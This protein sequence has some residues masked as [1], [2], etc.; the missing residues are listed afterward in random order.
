MK[1]MLKVFLLIFCMLIPLQA[2]FGFEFKGFGD[3]VFKGQTTETKTTM[4]GITITDKSFKDNF[5]LGNFTIYATEQLTDNLDALIEIVY[6]PAMTGMEMPMFM[7]ARGEIGY[8][9]GDWLNLRAGKFH[10]PL[11]YYSNVIRHVSYFD[12]AIHRPEILRFEM[13][14]GFLSLHQIG[15]LARGT[16]KISPGS[17]D[18]TAMISNGQKMEISEMSMDVMLMTMGELKP[19]ETTDD[20]KNKQITL[21]LTF[22]PAFLDGLG[23][24]ISGYETELHG[25]D[26]S[27]STQPEVLDT[28]QLVTE[29]HLYYNVLP[30]DI[31]SE[32]Y[33]INN[34]DKEAKKD[35]SNSAYF[36]QVAYEFNE[37]IRPYIRY[38][39]LSIKEQ[40]PYFGALRK[41]NKNIILGG[42]RY[43]LTPFS[44]IKIELKRAKT[45]G[46][47]T[48]TTGTEYALQWSFMF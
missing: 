20:N 8:A 42:I 26:V 32:Y 1:M 4:K 9:F 16:A 44:A 18:Y 39:K 47:M 31:Y 30:W 10:T 37:K 5:T 34:R 33:I 13:S 40:D 15:F 24:G 46:S 11:G 28:H 23:I 14:G 17:I 29:V 43:N 6:M 2:V 3:V 19:L 21:S 7:L 22:R 12:S 45:K 38:E 36:I 27:L 48:E 25:Y 41:N 35:Y